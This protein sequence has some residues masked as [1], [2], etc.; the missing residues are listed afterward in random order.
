[1]SDQF[2]PDEYIHVPDKDRELAVLRERIAVMEAVIEAVSPFIRRLIL[3]RY[4]ADETNDYI[5]MSSDASISVTIPY[6]L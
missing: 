3:P 6:Y 1:M 2:P 5:C 4:D